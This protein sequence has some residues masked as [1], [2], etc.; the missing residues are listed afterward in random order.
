MSCWVGQESTHQTTGLSCEA[1]S[2]D[3]P[4]SIQQ[5][6]Q[7]TGGRSTQLHQHRQSDAK[8]TIHDMK[9]FRSEV[10]EH[11]AVAI[12]NEHD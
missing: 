10:I 7:Q 8:F 3:L 9:M 5:G 1:N 2:S 6:A 11:T 4:N 12:K